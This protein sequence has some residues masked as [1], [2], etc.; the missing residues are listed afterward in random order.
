MPMNPVTL[1]RSRCEAQKQTNGLISK[2][3]ADLGHL[4]SLVRGDSKQRRLQ[5]EKL[6]NDFEVVLNK[7]SDKQ[8]MYLNKVRKTMIVTDLYRN[9]EPQTDPDAQLM[10]Q[11]L[12]YQIQM[13]DAQTREVQ[14]NQIL[15][16]LYFG[17][18]LRIILIIRPISLFPVRG[19]G[20][21]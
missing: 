16:S 7:Y 20:C 10:Q 19:C 12:Q 17:D 21:E 6:K 13:D 2:T 1:P 11:Q 14:M 5:V 15:V 9:E 3:S 18:R 8:M 4:T